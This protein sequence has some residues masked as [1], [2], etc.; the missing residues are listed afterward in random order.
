MQL[1]PRLIARW[2]RIAPAIAFGLVATIAVHFA[3]H[4][5]ARWRGSVPSLTL[6]G[7]VAHALAGAIVGPRLIDAARTTSAWRAL[8]LGAVTS[9]LALAMFTPPF[10]LWTL[11]PNSTVSGGSPSALGYVGLVGFF[12]FLA[13]GWFLVLLS[14]GVGYALNRLATA[15]PHD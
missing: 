9:V 4:A 14:A 1:L 13:V 2:P 15:R 7:G 5:D 11:T 6:A 8:A 10:A 3:W 12:G